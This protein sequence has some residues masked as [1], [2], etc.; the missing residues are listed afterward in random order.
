MCETEPTH[1]ESDVAHLE[2]DH[3]Q[4]IGYHVEPPVVVTCL[5]QNIILRILGLLPSSNS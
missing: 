4:G 2:L 1:P 5:S 3:V